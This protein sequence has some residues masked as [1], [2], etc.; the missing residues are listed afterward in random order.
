MNKSI[1]IGRLTADPDIR[2]TQNGKSVAT[3]RLAVDRQF[4]QDGQDDADFIPCVAWG[5]QAEF[6]NRYLRKGMKIAIEGRIQ[7]RTFEKDGEKRF[8]FEVIAERHEFVERKADGVTTEKPASQEL[9]TVENLDDFEE[10][11]SDSGVPF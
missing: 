5:N 11:L 7:T 3:Y 4:K 1:L 10:I 8:A 2:Q 9:P 6:A